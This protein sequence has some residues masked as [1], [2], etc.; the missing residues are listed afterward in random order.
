MSVLSLDCRLIGMS[1]D[2]NVVPTGWSPSS[3]RPTDWNSASG[4]W[5]GHKQEVYLCSTRKKLTLC[6]T[7]YKWTAPK[8]DQAERRVNN[9]SVMQHWLT[10][11]PSALL[12]QF[13]SQLTF[14]ICGLFVCSYAGINRRANSGW[15][16]TV[17]SGALKPC[18]RKTSSIVFCK[19]DSAQSYTVS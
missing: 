18:V 3:R 8:F 10:Y 2:W 13:S 6:R 11:F 12:A 14:H 16:K 19:P 4:E 17:R 7:F 1:S 9:F 15:I 5:Y